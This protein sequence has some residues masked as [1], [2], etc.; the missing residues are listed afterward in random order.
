MWLSISE[1]LG[2]IPLLKKIAPISA[3]LPWRRTRC[4]T[5]GLVTFESPDNSYDSL[6]FFVSPPPS[7]RVV[8]VQM[9]AVR[10]FCIAPLNPY[11]LPRD[12]NT[13][14]ILLVPKGSVLCPEVLGT[15]VSGCDSSVPSS[16]HRHW[17]LLRI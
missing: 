16:V 15:S 9:R 3:N 11:E 8:V 14:P 7:I 12:R 2:S 5:H 17:R 1:V 10:R 13:T 6:S 4:L